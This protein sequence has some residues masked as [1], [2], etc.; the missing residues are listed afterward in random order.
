MTHV[1]NLYSLCTYLQ[2]LLWEDQLHT[3]ISERCQ[4]SDSQMFS[5]HATTRR[6]IDVLSNRTLVLP[7]ED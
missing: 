2:E 4:P 1:C 3:A 6:L 7:I 5:A